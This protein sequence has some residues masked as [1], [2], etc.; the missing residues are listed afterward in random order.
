MIYRRDCNDP[1]FLFLWLIFL[2]LSHTFSSLL[3]APSL[4]L[5]GGT[6]G[7]IRKKRKRPFFLKNNFVPFFLVHQLP[8]LGLLYSKIYQSWKKNE[9]KN[10]SV[11]AGFLFLLFY[12]FRDNCEYRRILN[13]EFIF[14]KFWDLFL[15]RL[16]PVLETIFFFFFGKKDCLWQL[17]LATWGNLVKNRWS[18]NFRVKKIP[19]PNRMFAFPTFCLPFCMLVLIVLE[20]DEGTGRRSFRHVSSLYFV[21]ENSVK[22]KWDLASSKSLHPSMS[23]CRQRSKRKNDDR[24]FW[25]LFFCSDLAVYYCSDVVNLLNNS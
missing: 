7:R 16:P 13:W 21:D 11:L 4:S 18:K 8:S 2:K 15:P 3:V 20:S 14:S 19:V 9:K 5:F 12:F 25:K 10:G 17:V 23:C 24:K 22:K 6:S 1:D